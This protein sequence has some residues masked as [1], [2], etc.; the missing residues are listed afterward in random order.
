MNYRKIKLG[1]VIF[2]ALIY[3]TLATST[4]VYA[5][6]QI[7]HPVIILS[8]DQGP[9]GSNVIINGGGFQEIGSIQVF[10]DDTPM[11]VTQETILSNTVPYS[12]K[13]HATVPIHVP[14]TLDHEHI[15]TVTVGATSVS[16]TFTVTPTPVQPNE[17]TF[18]PSQGQ[19][20]STIVLGKM[21][22]E[23][24][25]PDSS[26]DIFVNFGTTTVTF[27]AYDTPPNLLNSVGDIGEIVVPDVPRGTYPVEV[28]FRYNPPE[29]ATKTY[30]GMFLVEEVEE[31]NTP[32]DPPTPATPDSPWDHLTAQHHDA[33]SFGEYVQDMNT[34]LE[35]WFQPGG[36]IYQ[37]VA[38]TNSYTS[39][40]DW[41][42]LARI[43]SEILAI[44]S[45]CQDIPTGISPEQIQ[46]ILDAIDALEL[47]LILDALN[48]E[49]RFTDD[50]ELGLAQQS[51][52]DAI[53]SIDLQSLNDLLGDEGRYTDDQELAQLRQVLLDDIGS[54]DL[55]SIEDILGDESRYTD[56]AELAQLLSELSSIS[57]TVTSLIDSY[58]LSMDCRF[59]VI[60]QD[61]SNLQG[62]LATTQQVNDL[63]TQIMGILGDEENFVSDAELDATI[64]ELTGVLT[65]TLGDHSE[66][67]LAEIQ[68][69]DW[70]PIV[71]T[72]A[73][74]QAIQGDMNANFASLNTRM[75]T[76]E[77]LLL[78]TGETPDLVGVQ[79][80][81][82]DSKSYYILTT[83]NGQ[84]HSAEL[85]IT[86]GG[87]T[88]ATKDHTVSEIA[89]GLY[90]LEF[91]GKA[92]SNKDPIVAVARIDVDGE[93]LFASTI[94]VLQ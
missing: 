73:V 10:F 21:I 67:I 17:L 86:V 33:G 49:T 43:E 58:G 59:T 39:Q 76:F 60:E 89:N 66:L 85:T 45:L 31:P 40:I 6:T 87:K 72:Y 36:S 78:E 52:L 4:L 37:I 79:I 56:D 75:D 48:D 92:G 62:H 64:D 35:D 28:V 44:Q 70:T 61:L 30:S 46:E 88:V 9:T 25:R 93:S 84:P 11:V 2:L 18:T 83:L 24:V 26:W 91:R 13:I 5:Q 74:V 71:E 8:P 77:S 7:S 29:V 80:E 65:T 82:A 27:S 69:L 51:I 54:I 32:T 38:E 94:Q 1:L 68:A 16:E 14:P 63:E 20:G 55:Q 3:S 57:D 15:I 41:T 22:S 90:S 53:N 34:Q 47:Q 12:F 23:R 50:A 42:D 19:P 81:K